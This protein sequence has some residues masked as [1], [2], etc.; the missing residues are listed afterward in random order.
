MN[1][2]GICFKK[3]LQLET[4]SLTE[5]SDMF[6]IEFHGIFMKSGRV[7][8]TEQACFLNSITETQKKTKIKKNYFLRG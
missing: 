3:V 6:K 2:F 7:M 8:M 5:I 4:E 1:I